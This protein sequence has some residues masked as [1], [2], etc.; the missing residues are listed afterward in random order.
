[1]QTAI[2]INYLLAQAACIMLLLISIYTHY[3]ILASINIFKHTL[4]RQT[5]TDGYGIYKPLS[6]QASVRHVF[7][8]LAKLFPK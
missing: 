8:S 4:N 6:V 5:N 2:S 1:M 3:S 7:R